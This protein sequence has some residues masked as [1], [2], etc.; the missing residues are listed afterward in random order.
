[1]KIL[2][3][4]LSADKSE[5]TKVEDSAGQIVN[6]RTEILKIIKNFYENLYD[7]SND[8]SALIFSRK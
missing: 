4:K 5:V 6:D 7:S 2:K 8:K 3:N 1:M